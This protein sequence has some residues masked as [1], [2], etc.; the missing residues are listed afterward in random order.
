MLQKTSADARVTERRRVR[1]GGV[2]T[3]FVLAAVVVAV[4]GSLGWWQWTRASEQGEV[5]Q[6]LPPAPIAEVAQPAVTLGSE[7]GRDVWVDG[8][9]ANE[10]AALVQGRVVD[11]KPA[12]LVIRAFTVDAQATG[13]GAAAT[14]PVVVGWLSPTEVPAFDTTVPSASRVNGHLRSGEGAQPVPDPEIAAPQGSF[15]ADRLSPAV[16]AQHWDSPL[17]SGLLTA[18]EPEDGLQALPEPEIERT[19]DFRSLAYAIEWWLFGG[20]F[21]Y[22]A[23][24]WIRD[25]GFVTHTPEESS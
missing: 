20:F 3:A 2:V 10:D 25:N 6:P 5:R 22:L 12:V 23:L 11:G 1:W 4:C 14:L 19:L 8:A 18:A 21:T 17:Y 15:W 9:F 13:N 7:F 16:L 24:R